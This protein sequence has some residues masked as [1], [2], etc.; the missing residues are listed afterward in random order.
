MLGTLD[1]A[2]AD[3]PGDL[4]ARRMKALV[5]ALQG[6]RAEAIRQVE[7]VLRVA[8][9]YEKALDECLTYAIDAGD[10]ASAFEPARRAVAVDPAS[11]VFHERMAFVSVQRQDWETALRESREALRI[12]PF[13]R[14]ARM[15]LIQSLLHRDD[16]RGAEEAFAT[17]IGLNPG[18]RE[19]LEQWFAD[20]RLSVRKDGERPREAR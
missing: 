15:F 10:A 8:P 14:F 5:L 2:L 6:R 19:S 3:R 9:S 1:R 17:L 20:Q 18:L 11:S 13:L 4:D 7:T 16:P 12:D